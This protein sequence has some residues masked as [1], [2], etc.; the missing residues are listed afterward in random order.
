MLGPAI[1]AL[2]TLLK[3]ISPAMGAG[4]VSAIINALIQIIPLLSK[5]LTDVLPMI[6]NI[7]A[8]LRNNPAANAELLAQ[9]ADLDAQ[10]DAAFD[11]AAAAAEAED[12]GP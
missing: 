2:L 6:K 12:S 4:E 7:I 5:E 11:A 3:V 10:V 1:T 8:A 9:L